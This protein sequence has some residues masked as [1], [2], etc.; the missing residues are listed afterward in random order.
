MSE[1]EDIEAVYLKIQLDK[2]AICEEFMELRTRIT[3]LEEAFHELNRNRKLKDLEK[4]MLDKA[5]T[6]TMKPLPDLL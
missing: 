2:V 6:D 4:K 3:L 5:I 1:K